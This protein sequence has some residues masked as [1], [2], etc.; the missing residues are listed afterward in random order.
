MEELKLSARDIFSYFLVGLFLLICL[1]SVDLSTFA[2]DL[3]NKFRDVGIDKA[4]IKEQS[5]GAVLFLFTLATV[6][7]LGILVHGVDNV[8][9]V[10][11]LPVYKLIRDSKIW[12]KPKIVLLAS[13]MG[14]REIFYN[15]YPKKDLS[16]S[17]GKIHASGDSSYWAVAYQTNEGFYRVSCCLLL[18]HLY[19]ALVAVVKH[20]SV[21]S[22]K[23]LLVFWV[24]TI[25]FFHRARILL[26]SVKVKVEVEKQ[27]N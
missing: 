25:L 23:F 20:S 21:D 12:E 16:D 8:I 9:Y 4:F 15:D 14:T 17:A 3:N 26:A 22:W 13:L 18:Y 6:Y 5:I 27:I 19:A 11:I 24:L 7:I 10:V 1:L 2:G